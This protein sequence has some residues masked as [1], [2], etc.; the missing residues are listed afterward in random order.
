[1]SRAFHACALI[2]TGDNPP[3]KAH[4]PYAILD[5]GSPM[6]L[7]QAAVPTKEDVLS[8]LRAVMQ[9]ELGLSPD[10]IQPTAHLVDDLDLDSIDWVDLAVSLEE[11]IGITLAEE[12]LKSVRTVQDAVDVIHAGLVA[13]SVGPA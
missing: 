10:R 9:S 2:P 3:W 5:G 11:S 8:E 4:E 6:S 13:R 7:S 1:M 12:E